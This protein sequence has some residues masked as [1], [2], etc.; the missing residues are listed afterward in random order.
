MG[1][2]DDI[3]IGDEIVNLNLLAD[4]YYILRY[5]NRSFEFTFMKINEKYDT[6]KSY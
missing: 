1:R 3:I 6:E 4:I 5:E 2:G